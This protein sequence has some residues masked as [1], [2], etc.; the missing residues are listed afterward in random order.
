MCVLFSEVAL[1]VPICSGLRTR[2]ARCVDASL[3]VKNLSEKG[4]TRS[5]AFGGVLTCATVTHVLGF[6]VGLVG[7]IVITLLR[8]LDN[9]RLYVYI[10]SVITI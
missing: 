5:V 8:C 2:S 1:S 9:T 6:I 4:K 7:G 10:E 3:E